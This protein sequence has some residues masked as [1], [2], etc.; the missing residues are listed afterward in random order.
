MFEKAKNHLGACEDC[1]LK[2]GEISE[3][4]DHCVLQREIT[5]GRIIGALRLANDS[6]MQKMCLPSERMIS[7]REDLNRMNAHT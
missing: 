4:L 3:Q 5:N 6:I 7:I 1:S 2:N